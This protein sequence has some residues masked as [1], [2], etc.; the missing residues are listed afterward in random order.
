[1]FLN[2]EI[3]VLQSRY[4]VVALVGLSGVG[5]STLLR[6]IAADI[7]FTHLEASQ[8]IK[9]E[10]QLQMK[11]RTSEE[12]RKGNIAGNQHLLIS[13]FQRAVGTR[14]GPFV[15]DGHVLIDTDTG[16][17]EIA[18]SVFEALG[19]ELF[20]FVQAAP[21]QIVEQRL[22]DAQRSRPNRTADEIAAQQ[23]LGLIVCGRIARRLGVPAIIISPQRPELLIA[24][25]SVPPNL[26]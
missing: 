14:P 9:S 16:I 8:L 24:A 1:M 11:S 4:D 20:C 17:V 26:T 22:A 23:D 13:G 2:R 12:L 10:L 25:L 21:E 15:V 18:S 6:H 7:E 19:V 3:W 5:K